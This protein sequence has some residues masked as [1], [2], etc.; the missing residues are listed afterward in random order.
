[1]HP[2]LDQLSETSGGKLVFAPGNWD[3]AALGQL[4][5]AGEVVGRKR[6]LNPR[7]LKGRYPPGNCQ[8]G[9]HR[10]AHPGVDHQRE[11]GADQRPRPS[12]R[13]LQGT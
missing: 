9:G 4:R 7:D 8:R 1:M 12:Y 6:L 3:G 13:A 10:P 5:V 2:P 11:V